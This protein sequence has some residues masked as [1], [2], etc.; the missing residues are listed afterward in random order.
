MDSIIKVLLHKLFLLLFIFFFIQIKAKVKRF[1][2]NLI[3]SKI[4]NK[5]SIIKQQ[6]PI[7]LSSRIQHMAEL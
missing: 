4:I 7:L 1:M 6:L 3:L 2:H 5:A